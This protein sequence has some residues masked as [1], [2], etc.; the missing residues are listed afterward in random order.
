MCNHMDGHHIKQYN[1]IIRDLTHTKCTT[2]DRK[3]ITTCIPLAPIG[4]MVKPYTYI[5]LFTH[6][7][8]AHMYVY[9]TDA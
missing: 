1:L 4:S 5:A 9:W 3:C 2:I 8:S 7:H 6:T